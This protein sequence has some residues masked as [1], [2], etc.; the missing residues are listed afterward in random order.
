MCVAS[1]G[2][3]SN[4]ILQVICQASLIVFRCVMYFGHAIAQ[5]VSRRLFAA[6][7][8][9]RAQVS[10]C[11]QRSNRAVFLRVFQFCLSVKFLSCSIVIIWPL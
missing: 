1:Y 8:Q 7:A 4:L 10:P 6:K 3:R 9:V 2:F 11:G 5:A